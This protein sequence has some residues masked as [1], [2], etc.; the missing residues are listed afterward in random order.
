MNDF[1][2]KFLNFMSG[3]YGVDQLNKFIFGLAVACVILSIFITDVFSKIAL[4]L[5]IIYLF[6]MLSKNYNRRYE[7]NQIYLK[8]S[9]KIRFRFGEFKR[10]MAYRKTHRIFKCKK[11]GKKLSVPKGKGNIEIS[12]PCGNKF[13]KKT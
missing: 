9:E 10:D 2:T 13:R 5:I 3:R 7:E 8:H 4:A 1:K 11:C 6:R 12:C